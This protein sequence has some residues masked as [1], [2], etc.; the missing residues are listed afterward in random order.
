AWETRARNRAGARGAGG[1]WAEGGGR[2]G[3]VLPPPARIGR[4]AKPEGSGMLA[5]TVSHGRPATPA[6]SRTA[7]LLPRPA[8]P[9]S[10]TGTRA[11]TATARAERTAAPISGT[12]P[13]LAACP[14]VSRPRHPAPP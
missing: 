3:P 13:A 5:I 11:A 14:G 10:N 2:T 12:S 1:A 7:E 6:I 8:P 4:P 9:H